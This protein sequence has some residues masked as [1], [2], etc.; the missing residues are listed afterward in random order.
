L[1]IG[2]SEAE[3]SGFTNN[4]NNNDDDDIQT[5]EKMREESYRR[6]LKLLRE[7]SRRFR[8]VKVMCKNDSFQS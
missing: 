3:T 6:G 8:K 4:D 2:F 7:C 1:V 5:T